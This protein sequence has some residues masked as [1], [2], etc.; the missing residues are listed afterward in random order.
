M[1]AAIWLVGTDQ[2]FSRTDVHPLATVSKLLALLVLT[3]V[4]VVVT[5]HDD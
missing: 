5:L 4:F 3:A 1:M 2:F